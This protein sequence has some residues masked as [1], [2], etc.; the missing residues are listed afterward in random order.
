MA[1]IK[2]VA[3]KS[4]LS[5]GTVSNYLNGREIR[6]GNARRIQEAIRELNYVPNKFGRYLRSG[7]S[8]TVGVI[9]NDMSASFISRT[10]AILEHHLS[11]KGYNVIF[12]DSH[13]DL[14]TEAAKLDFMMGRAVDAII[15][16]PSDYYQSDIEACLRADV[17]VI[18]CDSEILHHKNACHTVV[19]DN[20]RL[21]LE[22]TLHLLDCGHQRLACI[23]GSPSHYS[24][25]TR[26]DGYKSALEERGIPFRPEDVYYCDFD[27][28]LSYRAALRICDS[29][30]TA[31]FIT[32]N[33]MLLGFLRALKELGRQVPDD[34]SYA[35][36]A[37]AGYYDILPVM[38]TH[39]FQD[40]EAFGYQLLQLVEEV[41]FQKDEPLPPKKIIA[42]ARLVPGGSVRTL[43]NP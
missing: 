35:T 42:P 34:I 25:I 30:A 39:V 37:D 8:K 23:T 15:L 27:D 5:L 4:G 32:S 12:C 2:D 7:V 22:S 21:A 41:L 20:R 40:T 24:S 16:F 9:L 10:S 17:P 18:L 28:S 6:P 14:E 1:T 11:R 43:F 33:N 31:V 19:Y 26:V 13:G 36:F 3:R 38:P 29:P